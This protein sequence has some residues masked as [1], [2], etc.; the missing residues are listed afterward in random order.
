[1]FVVALAVACVAALR[2]AQPVWHAAYTPKQSVYE[3][4]YLWPADPPADTP[5]GWALV[6][7]SSSFVWPAITVSFVDRPG[8]TQH[9]T[10]HYAAGW[11][12]AAPLVVLVLGGVVAWWRRR[13]GL[14]TA[15]DEG[16]GD[17]ADLTDTRPIPRVSA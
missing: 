13:R 8:G 12:F 16:D 6:S 14:P 11:P 5:G 3:A 7:Y 10:T 4:D 1:L 2:E 9:T 15:S 17:G